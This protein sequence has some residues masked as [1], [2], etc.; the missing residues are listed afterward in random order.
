MGGWFLICLTIFRSS[1]YSTLPWPFLLA[2]IFCIGVLGANIV[3]QL[4]DRPYTPVKYK[5]EEII[6]EY[7]ERNTYY[8]TVA[9][10]IFLLVFIKHPRIYDLTNSV[11]ICSQMGA[12]FFCV[13][14]LA[15]CWMPT[16]KG[17]EHMLVH[18]RHIKTVFFTYAL[19]LFLLGVMEVYELHPCKRNTNNAQISTSSLSIIVQKFIAPVKSPNK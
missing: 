3:F 7:A 13:L 4:R 2:H 19:A 17:K 18:L 9:I 16:E 8:L 10:P 6:Y 11:L 5:T 1:F 14:G 15:L 12:L